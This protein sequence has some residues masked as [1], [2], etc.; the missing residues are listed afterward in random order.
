MFLQRLELIVLP[1]L[2]EAQSRAAYDDLN[3]NSVVIAGMTP[4]HCFARVNGP[5]HVTIFAMLQHISN[6]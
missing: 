3:G 2:N 1:E 4:L 5:N 6:R